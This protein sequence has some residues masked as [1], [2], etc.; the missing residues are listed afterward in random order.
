VLSRLLSH[1]ADGSASSRAELAR[2]TRLARSTVSQR[3]DDLLTTG[4]VLE[5]TGG[6]ST[7]G[8][9]PLRLRLNP[10]AGVILAVD[11]DVARTRVAVADLAGRFLDQ[12]I[13][14]IAIGEGPGAVLAQAGKR[15]TDLLTR[16]GHT[17]GDVR[18][19]GVSVIGPVEHSTGTVVRPP[20]MPGW[21][22]CRIPDHFREFGPAPIV[23][24]NDVN[25]M[26]LAEHRIHR[27]G[28]DHLLFVRIDTGIGCGIISQGGLHRGAQGAAGDIGHIQLPGDETPCSCGSTGCLEAVAGGA[29]LA[30]SLAAAGHDVHSTQDVT[31]LAESGDPAARSAVHV[32]SRRI[33]DVLAGLVSFYNPAVVAIGGELARLQEGLLTGIR[34]RI[35]DHA[36]PLATRSLQIEASQLGDNAAITGATL[37]AQQHILAPEGLHRFLS[38]RPR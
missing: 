3:V 16:S 25:L 6:Q 36:L 17:I 13:I 29:A 18:G 4:L 30:R 14:D 37:L 5:E 11:L 1:I 9:P 19:L 2:R 38:R 28:V 23:V 8:R 22:G 24:D 12:A 7:G 26:A 35:Y 27:P 31:R 32:A 33:G 21:D 15:L 20:I 10:D 34:S